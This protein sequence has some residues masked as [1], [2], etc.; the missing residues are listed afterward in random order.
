MYLLFRIYR[1]MR[2]SG[3]TAERTFFHLKNIQ[4]IFPL[5][6]RV[7][8][9]DTLPKGLSLTAHVGDPTLLHRSRLR[10]LESPTKFYSYANAIQTIST[11]PGMEPDQVGVLR[12]DEVDKV[13]CM[14][15]GTFE[16]WRA[17]RESN[18]QPSDPK[19]DALSIELR[20]RPNIFFDYL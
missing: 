2:S 11:H 19:S 15:H 7:A 1:L 10:F 13:P 6:E 5:D 9:P 12:L 8:F 3:L 4:T 14:E 16:R 20:A 17:R 18:P